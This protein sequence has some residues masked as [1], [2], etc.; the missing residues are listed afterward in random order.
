MTTTKSIL[1]ASL[2]ALVACGTDVAD[3]AATDPSAVDPGAAAGAAPGSSADPGATPGAAGQSG[4]AP[5]AAGGD[6]DQDDDLETA[7]PLTNEDVSASAGTALVLR[8]ADWMARIPGLA[9]RPLNEIVVPGTHDSAT[10][11]LISVYDRPVDDVFAPDGEDPVTRLGE[12]VKLTDK[13][14]KAQSKD[15]ATQLADGMRYIDLRPCKEKSG[16]LR[17]CHSL[18]GPKVGDILD[19]VRAFA[20]AHP[21]EIVFLSLGGFAGMNDAD[22]ATLG[23][24]IENRLGPRIVNYAAGDV[25][26][27]TTLGDVW[28]KHPG[29]SVAVLY[30]DDTRRPSFFPKSKVHN[31]WIETW[32]KNEKKKSIVDAFAVAPA[33]SF[34]ITSGPATP[35]EGGKLIMSSVDPLGNFPKSLKE[36]ADDTNPVMLGWARDEWSTQRLNFFPVDFY[37]DTCLYELAMKL[38]GASN[39]SFDGCN[40]G[41]QTPWGSYAFGPYGRGAGELLGCAAGQEKIA[42]L[43]YTKCAPG[44]TS[45]VLFPTVCSQPCPAGYRDDGL[46]CFRDA[47]IISANNKSCPWYDKCGLTVKKGCSTCPSGY[48]ND[49]CT[50]RRDAHMIVKSRYD[51]GVGTIPSSCGAGY[52]K[53]G[54]LCYPECRTGWNGVGPMCWPE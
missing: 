41:K 28:A 7:S 20:D 6:A 23:A 45:S 30:P 43:C 31:S 26:P 34:F 25:S 3:D 2:L 35:D 36:L 19:Q 27:T 12:F 33:D 1:I 51:R 29:Q 15:V 10:N 44:Y 8:R 49:G 40:I 54:A 32:D 21:K 53:D 52:E 16:T 11:A 18:Y 37:E 46:T 47:K 39:I 50:C 4:G 14:S 9:D 42:G 5:G 24:L 13:W 17:I 48:S 38:N 22:H